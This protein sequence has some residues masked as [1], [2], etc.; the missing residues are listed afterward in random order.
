VFRSSGYIEI[1][2]LVRTLA[3][4]IYQHSYEYKWGELLDVTNSVLNGGI[5]V[6]E[7]RVKECKDDPAA[8]YLHN[9]RYDKVWSSFMIKITP[10]KKNCIGR[11][12]WQGFSLERPE[13]CRI[14]RG[15]YVFRP[16]TLPFVSE[17]LDQNSDAFPRFGFVISLLQVN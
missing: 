16:S 12:K 3:D 1:L 10:F 2:F 4:G 7:S 17:F 15:R 6:S 13:L 14:R 5:V 9:F 11:D 8:G